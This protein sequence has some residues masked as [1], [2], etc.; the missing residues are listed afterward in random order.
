MIIDAM[1]KE[2]VRTEEK[3]H[4]IT[5]SPIERINDANVRNYRRCIADFF[6]FSSSVIVMIGRVQ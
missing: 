5:T 2:K 1:Q 3:N 4:R 6:S